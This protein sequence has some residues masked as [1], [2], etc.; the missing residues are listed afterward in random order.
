M[1]SPGS[2]EPSVISKHITI[3]SPATPPPGTRELMNGDLSLDQEPRYRG[4]RLYLSYELL[5]ECHAH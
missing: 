2:R 1:E 5:G 4:V 3:S